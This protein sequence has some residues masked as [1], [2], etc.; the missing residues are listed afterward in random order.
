MKRRRPER[1]TYAIAG[2]SAP[3]R[4]VFGRRPAPSSPGSVDVRR[5]RIGPSE[6]DAVPEEA[7]ACSA[8]HLPHEQF[9]RGGAPVR[10]HITTRGHHHRPRDGSRRWTPAVTRSTSGTLYDAAA[11]V[12]DRFGAAEHGLACRE[13]GDADVPEMGRVLVLLSVGERLC[14]PTRGAPQRRGESSTE[15]IK[16]RLDPSPAPA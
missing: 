12:G 15:L 6:E 10:S 11:S 5:R 2:L 16:G 3:S 1:A 4:K 13:A 8:V 7:E 14:A 9:G